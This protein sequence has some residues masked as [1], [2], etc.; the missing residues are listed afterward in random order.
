MFSEYIYWMAIL[1]VEHRGKSES[2]HL[3]TCCAVVQGKIQW[4]KQQKN[5]I[6]ISPPAFIVDSIFSAHSSLV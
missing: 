5:A 2:V 6:A 1:F 3:D 4:M